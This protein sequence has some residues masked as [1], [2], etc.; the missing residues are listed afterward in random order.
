M[1][2]T[3][4]KTHT[5]DYKLDRAPSLYEYK[6]VAEGETVADGR[7]VTLL[8]KQA[9]LTSETVATISEKYMTPSLEF[10]RPSYAR[11]SQPFVGKSV[12]E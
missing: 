2:H 7:D 9:R 12:H 8:G 3:F 4:L 5:Q 10:S 6:P 1:T 11:Y